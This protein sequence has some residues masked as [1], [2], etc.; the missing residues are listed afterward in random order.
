MK[1]LIIG[2]ASLLIAGIAVIYYLDARIPRAT[3]ILQVHP[4][5]IAHSTS[6]V[7]TRGYMESE[8]ETIASEETLA[9]AAESLNLNYEEFSTLKG[10]VTS[11]PLRGSDFIK[12]TVKHQN[13]DQAIKIANAIAEAYA[14]RRKKSEESRAAAAIE[15]LDNETLSQEEL[16]QKHLQEFR[17]AAQTNKIT[18]TT[19]SFGPATFQLQTQE[20]TDPITA[21]KR[22]SNVTRAREE[23]E[24]SRAMLR[25]MKIKQ[26]ETRFTRNLAKTDIQYTLTRSSNLIGGWLTMPTT[27]TSTN[28]DLEVRDLILDSSQKQFFR[29]EIS[30]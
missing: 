26:Q 18:V 23:Y 12:I 29:I 2:I 20:P 7:M 17:T 1:R 13:A 16:V 19:N 15:A 30:R 6:G 22:L 8:F 9:M 5:T 3:T 27:A 11:E 21:S 14:Q 24:Q 28:G 25:E 10:K 4:S